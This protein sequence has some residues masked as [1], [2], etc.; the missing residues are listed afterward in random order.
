LVE[1]FI[2]P[3]LS[4]DSGSIR[5]LVHQARINPTGLDWRRFLVAVSSEGRIVGC[6]QVKNHGEEIRELASI[7]VRLD[8]RGNGIAR[9]IISQLLSSNPMPIYLMCRSGL[10]PFYLKFGFLPVPFDEMP[11]Y[12]RRISRLARAISSLSRDSE[13]LLVMKRV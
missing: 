10:E 8:S 9:Q 4:V 1:F 2:R 7:A 13:T 11:V 6:G 5:D 12:F 3:A